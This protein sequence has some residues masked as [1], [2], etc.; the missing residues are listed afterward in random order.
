M[1]M[2]MTIMRMRTG[3]DNIDQQR[4]RPEV[5]KKGAQKSCDSSRNGKL[6]TGE[7][8]IPT[9]TTVSMPMVKAM[10]TVC[11]RNGDSNSKQQKHKAQASR[12]KG[13]GNS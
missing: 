4:Q 8:T 5:M 2:T 11:D 12:C 13:D 6:A 7:T 10:V 9:T 3:K 1:T